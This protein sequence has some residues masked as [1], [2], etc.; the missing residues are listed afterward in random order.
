[1]S[2][3]S[4]E[5]QASAT[6]TGSANSG[7]FPVPAGSMLDVEVNWTAATALTALSIWLETSTDGGVTFFEMPFDLCTKSTRFATAAAAEI[8]TR[9]NGSNIINNEVA[10]TAARYTAIYKHLPAALMRLR[11]FLTGTNVTFSARGSVK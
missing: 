2:V 11:W 9:A 7:T 8:A 1:M 3:D 10:F 4:F 5:I 6:Q